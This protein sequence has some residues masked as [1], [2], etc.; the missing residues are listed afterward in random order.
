M[1]QG[2]TDN[3]GTNPVGATRDT[4]PN[5]VNYGELYSYPAFV[6]PIAVGFI[7]FVR[8]W[9]QYWLVFFLAYV[10]SMVVVGIALGIGIACSYGNC[11]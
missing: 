2:W 11:L 10:P 7:L 8:R 3:S 6:A 1:G 5:M 9:P 4:G